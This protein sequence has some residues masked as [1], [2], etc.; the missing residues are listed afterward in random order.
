MKKIFFSS[1][2][3]AVCLSMSA[4]S[5]I[6]QPL[7]IT[8]KAGEFVVDS[9]T[10]IS[11]E[12]ND[13]GFTKVASYLS[14]RFKTAAGFNMKMTTQS[15]GR[16]IICIRQTEG[17]DKEAYRLTLSP[18]IVLIESAAPN[19]AFYAVQTLCQMFPDAI[20]APTA[21]K[22]V[23]WTATCAVIEDAPR[24]PYRGMHLDV[25]S[26][27]F[28]VD[29]IKRYLDLMAIHKMNVFHWHLTEDQG[30]RIEIKRYPELTQKGAVRKET[31]IGTYKSKIYDGT[32]YGGFYTQDEIREIVRYA[33]DRFITVIP[34]IE[35]PG[36]SLAAI[37]CFPELSCGLEEKYEPATRWGVFRQVYCPKAT[38]FKFLENVL[39]EVMSLFPSE[40]IHIGGDECPKTSWKK[41]PHCQNLMVT[42]GLRDEF[43]LQSFFIQRMERFVN[44]RGRK[45]IGWDEIL[46]GGLAPNAMVMSWLGEE[47]GIKSAQ[48]H[49]DVVMCPHTK[50]YLDYYQADPYTEQLCMGHLVPLR[51]VYQYNPVPDTLTGEQKKYIRGVQACVWT[52][53]MTDPQRVEYMAFPRALA[54]CEA[55]WSVAENKEWNSFIRRLQTHCGRLDR[56]NVNYCKAFNDVLIRVHDDDLYSKVVTLS[57][58][59]PDAEIRYTIDGSEPTARSPIYSAPFVINRSNVVK[60]AGFKASQKTG[61]TTQRTFN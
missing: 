28:S 53:Y 49:H 6:P 59:A 17:F 29:F 15:A 57:I 50:Y 60:A 52:E 61:A 5:I 40:Y 38:T 19:G 21:N 45:I 4:Q 25:C 10:A 47:G 32:P 26:H 44:S 11:V 14:E 24:F 55:A 8:P 41:C 48:Q 37:S 7:S 30:W 51:E 54:I 42:L 18:E 22:N 35:M 9:R 33:A 31:V 1:F 20:Y 3:M 58:E 12:A 13:D 36:H 27:F 39:D 56:M 46:Q 16:N 23:K 34:E 43:E 2:L